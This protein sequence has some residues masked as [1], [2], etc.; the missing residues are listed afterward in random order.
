[1]KQGKCINMNTIFQEWLESGIQLRLKES[2]VAMYVRIYEAYIGPYWGDI[3][4][5][6]ITQEEMNAYVS[7]LLKTGCRSEKGGLSA[8]SVNDILTLLSSL[9]GYAAKQG[10]LSQSVSIP[11]PKNQKKAIRILTNAERTVLEQYC[12]NHL[13]LITGAI[14]LDLFTGLRIG[15]LC[16]TVKSYV[17]F[18]SRALQ[19]K[20][21]M[22]RIKDLEGIR[23]TKVILDT[24]KTASSL[25]QIPIASY[26]FDKLEALYQDL[27]PEAYLLTGSSSKWIEPRTMEYHFKQTLLKA[28]LKPVNFHALRH[29][30]AT[31]FYYET[32]DVKTLSEL[33]G[34]SSVAITY[35]TYVHAS[36]EVKRMGI[37][38]IIPK[39]SF[40]TC[41]KV[42]YFAIREFYIRMEWYTC[43]GK[44]MN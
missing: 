21:T 5:C 44:L 11:R 4:P 30:F 14:L 35:E 26:V 1:M 25:R 39:A 6:R 20:K 41:R 19:V 34:H 15:E 12:L 23:K 22:Q 8:K 10:Y 13:D 27:K 7:L 37:E 2:T 17:D 42:M 38:K 36:L 18:S 16:A 43:Y 24:P 31:N 29:T 9:L 32:L 33:L 40:R 28:G 3:E